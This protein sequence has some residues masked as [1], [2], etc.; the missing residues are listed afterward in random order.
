MFAF[1]GPPGAGK[2]TQARRLSQELGLGYFSPG[3]ELRRCIAEGSD[4]GLKVKRV[5]ESGLL[6][7]DGLILRLVEE[8]LG[9]EPRPVIFD[10]VPRTLAQAQGLDD[11]LERQARPLR[12]VVFFHL[13]SSEV[14]RRLTGRRVC[15]G[16]GET[17]NLAGAVEECSRCGGRLVLR[18]DDGIEVVRARLA[19]Y[20]AEVQRL[21][22]YY[23]PKG[24]L[25]VVSGLGTPEEVH[26][27]LLELGKWASS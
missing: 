19:A 23:G 24:I 5:V 9:R 11:L 27:R 20:E 13:P 4:L 8:Y 26:H 15:E 25:H 3:D 6:V 21:F 2:G 1:L 16:C 22:H 12:R 18:P 14:V 17:Y 10:G 7:E